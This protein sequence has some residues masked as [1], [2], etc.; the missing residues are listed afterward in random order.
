MANSQ[1]SPVSVSA[2]APKR[3]ASLDILRGFDMFL[4]VFLQPV[5]WS[6]ASLGHPAWLE[7]ILHQLD[8]EVWEGFRCWD[9]V[10][11]LFL[12][13]TGAAM[14]FSFAKYSTGKRPDAKLYGKI[15]RRFLLLFILGMVVQGNLL[16]FDFNRIYLYTNTLQSIATGYL[17]SAILLLHCRVRVQIV[18]TLALLAV[19]SLPMMLWGDYSPDGSFAFKVDELIL[20]R[21]RG[22][23]SY[24][25]VWSSLTF[26]VTVMCGT[27]AGRIIRDAGSD[28]NAAVVRLVLT[29]LVMVAAGWLWSFEQP[30]IKRIWTG[31]MTLLS[32]G[33]CFLLMAA[34]YYWV[35]VRG[36]HLG[37]DWLKIYGMNS[38]AAYIMG[39]AIDFRSIARSLSY[40]LEPYLGDY[41]GAWLTFANFLIVFLIL[42]FMYRRGIFL[43]I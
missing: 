16:G 7:P 14:P 42:R 12:F 4:L 1:S 35:D 41:Y 8:H 11:P 27:F 34:F 20:G 37:L 28:G 13:M 29:G 15:A 33:Y 5:I 10:M 9:L 19:Y 36:N 21:F 39:E 24:T 18:W 32:G 31:S 23:L 3:L 30:I 17:V 40:G 26:S 2:D 6:F 38:I 25:W 22:D 43:K